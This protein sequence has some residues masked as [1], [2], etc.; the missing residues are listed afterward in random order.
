MWACIMVVINMSLGHVYSNHIQNS[1]LV[2]YVT[3]LD[4]F[5]L[6]TS[7]NNLSFKPIDFLN[8]DTIYGYSQ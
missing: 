2:S 3:W 1:S 4:L 8:I 7:V 5:S 6:R